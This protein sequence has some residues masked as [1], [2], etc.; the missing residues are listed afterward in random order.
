VAQAEAA[1]QYYQGLF[2]ENNFFLEI[3]NNGIPIQ[4]TVNEGLREM[5]AKLSIP[6]VASNDCHYL[7]KE[8]ARAH[9]VL[10]CVQTGKTVNDT[11]RFR[12]STD[13][14]YFKPKEEMAAYFKDF[15]RAVGNTVEI[16]RRCQVD[17]D[18]KSYHFP[19][20]SD[21]SGLSAEDLFVQQTRE[22]F[23]RVWALI[24][25]KNPDA[26]EG[27][28]RQRL[29]YEIGIINKMGFPGYFLIVADFINYAKNNGVPVGPGRGPRPAAWWPIPW[30][31]LTWIPSSTA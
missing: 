18:F 27:L 25:N 8:D 17:F 31:S 19:Q 22:G 1:A 12:F 14:L 5:S 30:E 26:D 6:L 23:K 29:D 16:A 7:D 20:F 11:G 24:L 4:N 28:Y 3:Q 15:D 2:G 10:L 13:Q 9:D 21:P